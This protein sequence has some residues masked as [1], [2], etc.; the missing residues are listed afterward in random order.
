MLFDKIFY[1]S[2][3]ITMI[4]IMW[5][6]TDWFVYYTELVGLFANLRFRYA[7][8]LINY[9]E[10]TF[11]RFL[12]VSNIDATNR[13]TKFFTK[14]GDCPFCVIFWLSIIASLLLREWI[15]VGPCYV[16]SLALTLKI[17]NLFYNN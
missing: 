6:Y 7:S 17:R 3:W 14:L 9:P 5:F 10:D 15:I 8:H 11:S 4:S 12:Y 13:I 1:G 2:L 16:I